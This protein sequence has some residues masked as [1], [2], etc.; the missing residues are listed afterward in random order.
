[1]QAYIVDIK[2]CGSVQEYSRRRR[3]KYCTQLKAGSRADAPTSVARLSVHLSDRVRLSV[4]DV[5]DL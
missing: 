1:M 5:G 4:C 3:R 2:I